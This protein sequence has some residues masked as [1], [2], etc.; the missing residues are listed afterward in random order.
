DI[1]GLRQAEAAID[2]PWPPALVECLAG[3]LGCDRR[4]DEPWSRWTTAK[5]RWLVPPGSQ[6][7]T[8][9][10]A[11]PDDSVSARRDP[12]SIVF[13][14]CAKS[15]ASNHTCRQS[16][17]LVVAMSRSNGRR[18]PPPVWPPRVGDGDESSPAAFE[19]D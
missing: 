17:Y 14:T 2:D 5:R 9:Q 12:V 15:H 4:E 6:S 13:Q 11:R 1:E 16:R 7:R 8:K 3:H 19:F 18:P 10:Y